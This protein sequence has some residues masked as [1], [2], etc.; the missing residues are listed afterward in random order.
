MNDKNKYRDDDTV[1]QYMHKVHTSIMHVKCMLQKSTKCKKEKKHEWK[2]ENY[3]LVQKEI[4]MKKEYDLSFQNILS[5]E[6]SKA[7]GCK[8][9]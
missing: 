4:L 2:Q 3:N 6:M 7:G 5:A 8:W 9:S 1:W